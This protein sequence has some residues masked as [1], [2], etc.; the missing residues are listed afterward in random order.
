MY[1]VPAPLRP[2]MTF[3]N[4]GERDNALGAAFQQNTL[5]RVSAGDE[6]EVHDLSREME[7]RFGPPPP[8]ARRLVELMRLKTELRRLRVAH[9]T[10]STDD[11]WLLALGRAL[12]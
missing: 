12:R 5:Q 1:V 8:A 4:A 6:A 10:L 2:V 9:V 3:V 7:D 11:D